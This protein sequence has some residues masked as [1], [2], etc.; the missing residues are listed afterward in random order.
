MSQRS[1][2]LP[3]PPRLHT[4]SG[5]LRR[6]G[7]EL[8]MQG[9][10]IEAMSAL[11]AAEVGG[12]VEAVSRYEHRV[13]G[14]AAGDWAVEL[15]FTWLRARGRARARNDA[16]RDDQGPLGPLDEAAEELLAAG[17]QAVVPMEVV[18]PPLPMTRL[19]EVESLIARL[20]EAGARGTHDGLAFAFGLHLNPELPDTEAVTIAAYLKAFVC[21][22]DWL[23]AEARLDLLRRLM[24]YIDPY[25]ADYVRKVIDPGYRPDLARLMDDYL[26]DNPT[27]NRALDLLPLFAH[28]DEARVR[29][30]VDDPRIKP[31]PA[32]HYRLPNCQIDEPGWGVRQAWCGWLEVERL[33]GEPRRLDDLCVRYL[34]YLDR[35]LGRL[36]DDWAEQVRPWLQDP[37]AR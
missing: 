32:L 35:P 34:E 2:S 18:S 6:I 27:R 12:T 8:E 28:L 26:R 25:P 5:A 31:R 30:A 14:D 15:D 9:L 36:M 11:V 17:S 24:V 19:H 4:R 37:T 1:A 3:M 29:A 33:A 21:L 7:V 23:K 16:R 22:F 13:H 20:R 10:P